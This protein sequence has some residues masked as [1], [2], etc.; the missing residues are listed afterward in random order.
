LPTL[1][2]LALESSTD[3][4]SVALWLDGRV[5]ARD[6]EAGQRNSEVLLPMVDAL[7]TAHGLTARELD[8]VAYGSGP[9]S[10]TG[11]R[12]TCGVAQGIAFGAGIPVVGVVT[13]LALAHASG[14]DRVVCSLDARMGEIYHAAYEK[15]GRTWHTA[16]QPALCKPEAAPEPPAGSWTGCGSGF[17]AYHA[18]LTSRCAGRLERVVPDLFPHARDVANLAAV[19]LKSGGGV[20]AE[21]AEPFYLRNKVALRVD[22]RKA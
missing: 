3:L 7:L 13:L 15:R 2:I 1:N 11:L 18:V 22:E 20:A 9:G 10:F 21:H 12:V 4:C 16:L 6:A 14:A 17:D 8:G 5:Y 19:E